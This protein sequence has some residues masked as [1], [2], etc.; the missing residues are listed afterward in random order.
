MPRLPQWPVL[1]KVA[2]VVREIQ[3]KKRPVQPH[4]FL[5]GGLS[6]AFPRR[7]YF[8]G[9]FVLAVLQCRAGAVTSPFGP[10]ND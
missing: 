7:Q 8:G 1:V 2:P 3:R 10:L 4:P 9:V 5:P 6:A